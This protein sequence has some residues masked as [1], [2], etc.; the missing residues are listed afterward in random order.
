MG[1][2]SGPAQPSGWAVSLVD[3]LLGRTSLTSHSLQCFIS[4][5]AVSV[6]THA[7]VAGTP[8]K[9]SNINSLDRTGLR[10]V[11]RLPSWP[12]PPRP[13]YCLVLDDNVDNGEARRRMDLSN[14]QVD[15]VSF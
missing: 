4:E 9:S 2:R 7:A 12:S 1:C 13:C 8:Y 11:G 10:R 3:G 14:G 6:L 15:R 5:L